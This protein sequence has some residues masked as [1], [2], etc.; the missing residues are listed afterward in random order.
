MADDLDTGAISP[1]G[2]NFGQGAASVRRD[3]LR[4]IPGGRRRQVIV[5]LSDDEQATLGR[6]ARTAGVSVQRYLVEA[7]LS[8]HA[9]D[10]AARRSAERELMQARAVLRAAGNNLNQLTK[11]ANANGAIPAQIESVLATVASATAFVSQRVD[12][13][14]STFETFG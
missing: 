1:N 2:E 4:A 9:G 3:R 12:A 7:G 13:L 5:R 11:W 14:A 10:G 6:R 8:G